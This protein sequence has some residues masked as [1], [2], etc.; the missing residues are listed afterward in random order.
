MILCVFAATKKGTWFATRLLFQFC[1]DFPEEPSGK[2]KNCLSE[3]KFDMVNFNIPEDLQSA[4]R[5]IRNNFLLFNVPVFV[6]L[7]YLSNIFD[8]YS[9]LN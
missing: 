3:G 1:H 4:E 7:Y 5:H 2:R 9:I 8:G 6:E